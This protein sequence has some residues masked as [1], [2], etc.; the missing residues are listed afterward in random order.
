MSSD[1]D[2]LAVLSETDKFKRYYH[3]VR[4]NFLTLEGEAIAKGV[5][6][7]IGD[8]SAPTVDWDHFAAWYFVKNPMLNHE[9]KD[10]YK[11][12]FDALAKK[13]KVDEIFTRKILE[14]LTTKSFAD[15]ISKKAA[16]ISD[17]SFEGDLGDI[18]TSLKEAQDALTDLAP[19]DDPTLA[20]KNF[21]FVT[22]AAA[23]GPTLEFSLEGLRKATRGIRKGNLVVV[24][25]HP[26]TGKTTFLLG[27]V[28]HMLKQ[29][30]DDQEILYFNNEQAMQDMQMRL[31]TSVTGRVESD[32]LTDPV[33][34]E[35]DFAHLGGY[36]VH[37]YDK[38]YMN[39]KYV[40][41]RIKRHGK[42]GLIVFDQL[43][44]IRGAS[45][46]HNDFM[47]L[48]HIFAWARDIAKEHAPVI[49][50]HQADGDT[51][52]REKYLSMDHLFGSRIAIQGEADAIITIGRMTDG[53]TR[54][55]LRHF[56]VPKNKLPPGTDPTDREP[57]FDAFIDHDHVKYKDIK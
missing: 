1:L 23:M 8:T 9:K 3:H 26:N 55:D 11:K 17:G 21:E 39:I 32:V 35:R 45:K 57:R 28:S 2:M 33:S 25:A 46:S 20:P 27:E 5:N 54:T 6:D 19:G 40:Q 12:I 16:G 49:A 53:S 30:P 36:R 4:G 29:L 24:G 37:L 52:G 38:S 22:N 42:I 15:E 50:V 48:A 18:E 31:V 56:H 44:K 13:P 14:E 47:Q 41:E 10:N 51:M 34:V 7:Y 43:W